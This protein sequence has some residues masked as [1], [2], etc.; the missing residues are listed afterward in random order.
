MKVTNE[1]AGSTVSDFW[2]SS[3]LKVLRIEPGAVKAGD[4]SPPF[5]AGMTLIGRDRGSRVCRRRAGERRFHEVASELAARAAARLVKSGRRVRCS[6]GFR[7][8][9]RAKLDVEKKSLDEKNGQQRTAFAT[10]LKAM[11]PLGR[12]TRPR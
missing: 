3:E 8:M 12:W 11:M 7:P 9:N 6:A 1:V 2:K 10:A 4:F 5:T